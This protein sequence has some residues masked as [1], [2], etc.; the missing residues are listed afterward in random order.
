MIPGHVDRSIIDEFLD[1]EDT[2]SVDDIRL[3]FIYRLTA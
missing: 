2:T 3:I 1:N